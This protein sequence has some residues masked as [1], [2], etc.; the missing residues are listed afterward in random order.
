MG[1]QSDPCTATI[2]WCIVLPHL[3]Y[4]AYS[5]VPLAKSYH[6]HLVLPNVYVNDDVWIQLKPH[7]DRGFVRL[8]LF[9]RGTSQKYG[10]QLDSLHYRADFADFHRLSVDF[11]VPQELGIKVTASRA[12]FGWKACIWRGAAPKGLSATLLSPSQCHAAF[13]T[14]SHTLG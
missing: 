5:A 9:P 8:F 12:P 10:S 1:A 2:F 6:S 7:I 14:M 11:L 4:S 3:L 13:G